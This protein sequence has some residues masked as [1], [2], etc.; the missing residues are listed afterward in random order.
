MAV[1]YVVL[2]RGVNVGGASSLRMADFAAV[3]QKAGGKSVKTYIQSG[4]AVFRAASKSP[5]ELSRRIASRLLQAHGMKTQVL[6]LPL[7]ELE[8]TLSQNPFS[9]AEREPRALHLFFLAAA[10]RQPDLSPLEKAR[11]PKERFAL[12]G[13]TLYL[14]APDGIGRSKLAGRVE[15]ALGVPATARNWRTCSKLL[16]IAEAVDEAGR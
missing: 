15:R 9:Q 2:L 5:A 11:G 10:P 4:N 8:K 14:L 7:R 1:T 16:E 6:V 13:K 12:K 3:L